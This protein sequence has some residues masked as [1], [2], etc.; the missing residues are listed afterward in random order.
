MPSLDELRT[1]AGATRAL[2]HEQETALL[3]AEVA[4]MVSVLFGGCGTVVGD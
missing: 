3:E 1:Q 4:V 2:L